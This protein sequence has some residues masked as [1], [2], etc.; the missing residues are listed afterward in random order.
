MINHPDKANGDKEKEAMFSKSKS[1]Y[2]TQNV[3]INIL[4]MG[5][6]RVD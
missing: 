6:K 4:G 5:N 1:V 3:A 2:E